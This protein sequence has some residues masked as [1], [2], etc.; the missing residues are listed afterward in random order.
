[1]INIGDNFRCAYADGNCLWTVLKKKAK[2]VYLC[3]IV[4]EPFE[5]DGKILDSD[6]AGIQKVFLKKEIEFSLQR[7]A[8]IKSN[9]EEHDKFYKN[10]EIGSTVHYHNGFG[11]FVKCKVNKDHKLVPFALVG[12]WRDYELPHRSIDGEVIYPYM[13]KLIINKESFKPNASNIYEFNHFSRKNLDPTNLPEVSIEAPVQT[14]E[15]KNN[16]HLWTTIKDIQKEISGTDPKLIL[17]NI[18]KIL[19]ET[20]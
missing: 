18:K 19:K 1:M 15:E 13:C 12:G 9:Q 14:E 6:Y 20:K 2:D 17:S 7:S 8:A 16:I 5:Y 3:E 10:L 4:N 11:N